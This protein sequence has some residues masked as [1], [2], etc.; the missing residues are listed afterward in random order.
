MSF[1]E[2]QEVQEP[3]EIDTSWLVAGHTDE[4]MQFLPVKG[5]RGWVM[6]VDDPRAGL[7]I[8]TMAQQ[9]GHGE[10]KA[11]SRPRSSADPQDCCSSQTIDE[12]LNITNLA[13]I[14]DECAD[15]IGKNINIMKRETGITDEEI[16]RIPALYRQERKEFWT[17]DERQRQL[18]N[19][20]AGS[21]GLEIRAPP[22]NASARSPEVDFLSVLEAGMPPNGPN[23]PQNTTPSGQVARRQVQKRRRVVSLYPATING[24][25]LSSRD[26]LA[27]NPWGPVIDGEDILAAA[28]R[29]AYARINYTVSYVDDW[30]SH[31]N[32]GGDVHCGSNVIREMTAQW[33]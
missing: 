29:A 8:L 14:Q 16:I 2:A 31:H 3:I 17:Y 21:A 22:A 11:T 24:V 4:F 33:W 23:G 18:S 25:V 26:I 15:A 13:R 1:L 9:A 19:Y 12:V 32:G 27:P 10:E 20:T 5:G 30:F 6:A 7:E 28:V